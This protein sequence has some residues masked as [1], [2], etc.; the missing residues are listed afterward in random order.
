MG[1]LYRGFQHLAIESMEYFRDIGK[2]VDKDRE[3][4]RTN[5]LYKEARSMVDYDALDRHW[6]NL[7]QDCW[8][9]SPPVFGKKFPRH[10]D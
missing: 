1:I 5:K 9:N 7:L 2:E 6:D 8:D 10:S 4:E 3:R